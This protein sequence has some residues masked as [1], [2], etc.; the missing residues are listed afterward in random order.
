MLSKS[1]KIDGSFRAFGEIGSGEEPVPQLCKGSRGI[2][3]ALLIIRLLCINRTLR[4]TT[5]L[6]TAG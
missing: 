6:K 2:S 5:N 3:F 4:I 1:L